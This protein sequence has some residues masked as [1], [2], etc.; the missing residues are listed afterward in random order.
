MLMKK[1]FY[2]SLHF[3]IQILYKIISF[4]FF[5][6]LCLFFYMVWSLII[7]CLVAFSWCSIYRGIYNFLQHKELFKGKHL[8][9]LRYLIWFATVWVLWLMRNKIIFNWL[10]LILLQL[11][12]KLIKVVSWGGSL[13]G[14]VYVDVQVNYSYLDWCMNSLGCLKAIYHG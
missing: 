8:R 14:K 9:K 5:V 10:L 13:V 3:S 2:F 1:I 7:L 11:L 12:L 6:L 4:L